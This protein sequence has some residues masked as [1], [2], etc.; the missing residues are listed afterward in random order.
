VEDHEGSKEWNSK[1]LTRARHGS[2]SCW[3]SFLE[4][5]S[6]IPRIACRPCESSMRHEKSA[7]ESGSANLGIMANRDGQSGMVF[8][9]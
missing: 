6:W 3:Q 1:I 8:S 9:A 4:M 5:I 2:K 7:Y